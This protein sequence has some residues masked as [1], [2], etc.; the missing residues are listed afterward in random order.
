MRRQPLGGFETDLEGPQI[1]V[2]DAD[3]VATESFSARSSLG[4]V[5][6]FDQRIHAE[7]EGVSSSRCAVVVV[8]GWP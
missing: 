8:D 3:A 4:L 1:A 2:V 7:L 6:H 5:M